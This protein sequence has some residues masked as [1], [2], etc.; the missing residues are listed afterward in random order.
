[1]LSLYPPKFTTLIMGKPCV[2]ALSL[3]LSMAFL[4]PAN[5][6]GATALAISTCS[7]G[8]YHSES[9]SDAID[10]FPDIGEPEAT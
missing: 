5:L 6:N 9:D 7:L 1:M 4:G 10:F 2:A 3:S 8:D